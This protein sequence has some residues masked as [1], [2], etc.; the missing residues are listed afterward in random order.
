M[1]V[2]NLSIEERLKLFN[3]WLEFRR[4]YDDMDESLSLDDPDFGYYIE[5]NDIYLT[6]EQ[7]EDPNYILPEWGQPLP[8]WMIEES[9]NIGK[10]CIASR[11]V[12]GIFKGFVVSYTDYYYLITLDTGK[13]ILGSCVGHIQFID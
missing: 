12:P 13:D 10:K 5:G 8:D 2:T 4:K 7:S 1:N 6:K 9:K 3:E 11:G